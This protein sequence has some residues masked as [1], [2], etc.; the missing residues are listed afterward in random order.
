MNTDINVK[1]SVNLGL[2][3]ELTNI[4]LRLCNALEGKTMIIKNAGD[5]QAM[6]PDATPVATS[7]EAEKPTVAEVKSEPEAKKSKE[8]NAAE[9]A[10][11]IMHETRQ[12]IEGEDYKTNTTSEAYK[13]YHKALNG[14][15]IRIANLLGAEKPSMLNEEQVIDFDTACSSL[16]VLDDGKI[17]TKEPF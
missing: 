13:K 1:V 14:E 10:R 17:G 5:Q 15:F 3:E 11:R 8:K 6:L 4:A 16:A 9:E 7:V 2:T 12:R